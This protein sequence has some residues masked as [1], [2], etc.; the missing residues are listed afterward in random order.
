ISSKPVPD[1]DQLHFVVISRDITDRLDSEK[2]LHIL[3]QAFLQSPIA[4]YI[5]NINNVIELCNQT[6]E[7]ICNSKINDLISKK[8]FE[9]SGINA[10]DSMPE[11]ILN[12]VKQGNSWHG[13]LSYTDQSGN[14]VFLKGLIFPVRNDLGEITNYITHLENITEQKKAR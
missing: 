12:Q 3:S 7:N 1:S 13:E 4:F 10:V 14:D 5:T 2:A 9:V 11:T 6:Y 8:P